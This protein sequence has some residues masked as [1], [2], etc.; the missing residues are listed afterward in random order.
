ML[1]ITHL[2]VSIDQ[3]KILNDL[4]LQIKPGEIH[5]LMGANGSGKSTLANVLAGRPEYQIDS[6]EISYQD[7]S[8]LTMTPDERAR[9][10]VFLSFQQPV[11]IPGVLDIYFLKAALNAKRREEGL[12]EI[13]AMDFLQLV[14]KHL[15][16]VQMDESMLYRAVNDGF[17]GGERKRNELLQ[18]LLLQ[19]RL[20]ILDELDSGLDIDALNIISS[21]IQALR[22]ADR[23]FLIISHYQRLVEEIQPDVVHILKD[24]SIVRSGDANLAKLVDEKGFAVL[25]EVHS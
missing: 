2:N 20:V 5:V 25:D 10:G 13:D 7:Q 1:N 19:P 12:A 14:R 3:K 17:S 21:Q 18:I 8:L 6:G 15:Q 22:S 23:S 24:G 4:S 9:K 11:A 16:T